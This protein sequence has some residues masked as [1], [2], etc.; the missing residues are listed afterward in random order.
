MERFKPHCRLPGRAFTLIELLIVVAIIAILAAI[1]VPNFL[2]AQTRAKVSRCVADMRSVIT[3]LESY[4]VD[5]NSY[6]V[7]HRLSGETFTSS[8]Y[9][10][11]GMTTPIAYLTNTPVDIFGNVY[12]SDKVAVGLTF[13]WNNR[14]CNDPYNDPSHVCNGNVDTNWNTQGQWGVLQSGGPASPTK[15][16]SAA[17]QA[18][19]DATSLSAG[20][21]VYD[22]TNGTIS[23]GRLV[24]VIPGNKAKAK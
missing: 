12:F 21:V 1:A 22:P 9:K 2:E 5:N 10:S 6:P 15:S 4:S 14:S 7:S 13:N 18:Y 3:G 20:E 16:D 23:F 11:G 24:R 8:N 17:G 19:W